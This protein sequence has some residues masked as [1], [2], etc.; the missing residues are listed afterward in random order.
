L[1]HLDR[2]EGIRTSN[3]LGTADPERFDALLRGNGSPV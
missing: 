3:R 2:E 1:V